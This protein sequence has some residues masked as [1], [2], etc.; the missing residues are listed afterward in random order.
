MKANHMTEILSDT[1]IVWPHQKV[2]LDHVKIF[3]P[4]H[5]GKGNQ[6]SVSPP[7]HTDK[8]HIK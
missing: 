1:F 3:N 8:S 6:I 7:G 2:L 5:N 4:I